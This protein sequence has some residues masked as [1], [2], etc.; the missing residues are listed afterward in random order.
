[1]VDKFAAVG[2]TKPGDRIAVHSKAQVDCVARIDRV[3]AINSMREPREKFLAGP[4]DREP[5]GDDQ[6]RKPNCRSTCVHP[7][8]QTGGARHL[9]LENHGQPV[10][11]D[12]PPCRLR[13][14]CANVIGSIFDDWRHSKRANCV[15][16]R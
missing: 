11:V 4:V 2:A 13:Q 8:G 3:A 5:A 10:G 15:G 9:T 6:P 1:M 14:T 16:K 12:H 7:T